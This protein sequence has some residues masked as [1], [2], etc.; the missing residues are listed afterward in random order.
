MRFSF[1]ISTAVF[2]IFRIFFVSQSRQPVSLEGGGDIRVTPDHK[3][4][5]LNG[6]KAASELRVGDRLVEMKIYVSGPM[7][8]IPEFNFP[9]FHVAAAKL[10]A[11]GV[12]HE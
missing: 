9:A 11:E 12:A 10:R 5:T 7:R 8:G 2:D 3:F 6:T 1:S 4:P